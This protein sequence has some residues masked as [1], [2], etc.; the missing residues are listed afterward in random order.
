MRRCSSPAAG[1]FRFFARLFGRT[2]LVEHDGGLD[3]SNSE[4]TT[5]HDV[6]LWDHES[7]SLSHVVGG[8][9][10]Y[11]WRERL[12]RFYLVLKFCLTDYFSGDDDSDDSEAELSRIFARGLWTKNCCLFESAHRTELCPSFSTASLRLIDCDEAMS[13]CQLLSGDARM[14][15]FPLPRLSARLRG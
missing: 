2:R 13:R 6:L 11:S 15:T 3:S 9:P 8:R 7:S 12:L 5:I 4:D 10:A 1:R 14:A